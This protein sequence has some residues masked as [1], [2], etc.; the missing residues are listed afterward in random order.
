MQMLHCCG[1]LQHK[2]QFQ[3]Q[4][5]ALRFII[6]VFDQPGDISIRTLLHRDHQV[7][8]GIPFA[9]EGLEDG[10]HVLVL[11]FLKDDLLL[12]ELLLR[13]HGVF[14]E[15]EDDCGLALLRVPGLVGLVG[16][17]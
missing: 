14:D 17:A 6:D 3:R 5:P 15:F 16:F 4:L 7:P 1:H 13:S 12:L 9:G 8:T 10:D 2:L 11:G